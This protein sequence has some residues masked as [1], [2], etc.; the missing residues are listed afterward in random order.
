MAASQPNKTT[1]KWVDD[2]DEEG[3]RPG[4][5]EVGLRK[6]REQDAGEREWEKN[7][8]EESE[9][10]RKEQMKFEY[11]SY[12]RREKRKI[13]EAAEQRQKDFEERSR[14]NFE[15]ED[16]NRERENKIFRERVLYEGRLAREKEEEEE[17]TSKRKEKGKGPWST[18]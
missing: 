5:L 11:Y 12:Q 4:W 16:A 10:A 9:R 18:Q 7:F 2:S 17:C 14:K 15:V 8:E 6:V 1:M 13:E 3:E